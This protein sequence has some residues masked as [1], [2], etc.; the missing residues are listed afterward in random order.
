ME[1]E[2]HSTN[3]EGNLPLLMRERAWLSWEW[4]V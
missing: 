3:K 1:E 2:I 4:S